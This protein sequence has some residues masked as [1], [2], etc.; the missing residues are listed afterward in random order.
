MDTEKLRP[1]LWPVGHGIAATPEQTRAAALHYFQSLAK[2][3]YVEHDSPFHPGDPNR[4]LGYRLAFY[5]KE[6]P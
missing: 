2:P 1:H 4:K 5:P 6:M 3:T